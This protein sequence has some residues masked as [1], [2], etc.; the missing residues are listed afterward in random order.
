MLLL[1]LFYYGCVVRVIA[2]SSSVVIVTIVVTYGPFIK[3]YPYS[4]PKFLLS[5][6]KKEVGFIYNLEQWRAI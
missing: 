6:T 3:Q 4:G 5:V 1:L 2:V